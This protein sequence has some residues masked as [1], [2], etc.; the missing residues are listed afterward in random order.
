MGR[1]SF[2][3]DLPFW[4]CFSLVTYSLDLGFVKVSQKVLLRQSVTGQ[5]KEEK[6][7]TGFKRQAKSMIQNPMRI[8]QHN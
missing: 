3:F 5:E 6:K 4:L 1:F 8:G 7:P 2:N